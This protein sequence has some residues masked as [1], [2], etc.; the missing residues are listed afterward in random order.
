VTTLSGNKWDMKHGLGKRGNDYAP[1][2]GA[3]HG[4]A[5]LAAKQIKE[6]IFELFGKAEHDADRRRMGIPTHFAEIQGLLKNL[7]RDVGDD[8]RLIEGQIKSDIQKALQLADIDLP[9]LGLVLPTLSTVWLFYRLGAN[10]TCYGQIFDSGDLAATYAT[11]KV[12]GTEMGDFRKQFAVYKAWPYYSQMA[13]PTVTAQNDR[14]T[15]VG[16]FFGHG[17]Q[18]ESWTG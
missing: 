18:F 6:R 11:W 9:P 5:G 12:T 3:T 16:N 4:A 10:F 17:L 1:A 14:F 13:P 8:A 15:I 7:A 2:G